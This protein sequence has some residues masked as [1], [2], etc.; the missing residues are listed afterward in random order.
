M[1][2]YLVIFYLLLFAACAFAY[3]TKGLMA[4]PVPFNPRLGALT[5]DD[6][7][8]R[9]L[10]LGFNKVKVKIFD[11]NGD[12]VYSGTFP[13]CSVIWNGR[14]DQGSQVKP[15]MYIIVVESEDIMTGLH[16]KKTIRILV[17]Y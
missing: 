9:A 15:G 2:Q 1:K 4:Y 10:N 14:N 13:G 6:T 17:A 7:A 16:G 8:R 12:R 3:N 5:I 11:I